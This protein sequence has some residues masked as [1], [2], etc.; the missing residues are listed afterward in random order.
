MS[1]ALA[2]RAMLALGE[3]NWHAAASDLET[4]HRL[5]ALA[6][7][8]ASS[9]AGLQLSQKAF[10]L[11]RHLASLAPEDV[12][13]GYRRVVEAM[14]S[15]PDP[16][17]QIDTVERLATLSMV[18]GAARAGT[19]RIGYLAAVSGQ[20]PKTP[21]S[22]IDWNYALSQVNAWYDRAEAAFRQPTRSTRRSALDSVLTEIE[23][24]EQHASQ[25]RALRH[26]LRPRRELGERVA[27]Q[28]VYLYAAGW[29]NLLHQFDRADTERELT[30]LVF[31][32]HGHRDDQGRFPERLD[33]L[34]PRYLTAVPLDPF[35]D[36]PFHY[37]AE[38]AGQGFVLYS[39]GWNEQ[40]DSGRE[41]EGNSKEDDIVVRY[42]TDLEA[43]ATDGE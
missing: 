25:G 6:A 38:K 31:A 43:P 10:Q 14:P 36:S 39:V 24:F 18:C 9:S 7:Q 12:R 1:R 41:R 23:L 15:F 2:A 30:R 21:V 33:E 3:R 29:A 42:P 28:W 11:D 35:S 27:Q 40:D 17:Q 34:V 32:L 22:L 37:R 13:A 20:V 16:G 5:A 19:T 8:G 4:L 26:W